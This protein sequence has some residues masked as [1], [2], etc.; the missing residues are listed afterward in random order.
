MRLTQIIERIHDQIKASEPVYIV[1]RFLDVTV[2]SVDL[3]MGVEATSRLFG[4]QSLRSFD[5][6]FLE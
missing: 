6:L 3:H 2:D 4:Y 1:L 5:V